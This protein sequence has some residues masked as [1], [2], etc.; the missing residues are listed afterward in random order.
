MKAISA[1]VALCLFLAEFGL[2]Q[3]NYATRSGEIS[4]FSSAPLEDI[5]AK[6][7]RVHALLDP[8]SG[9]VAVRMRMEDFSFE[10]ALMQKHFNE[11]F[12][13]SHIYPEA[14]FTGVISDF[15]SI[16]DRSGVFDVKVKGSFT[17]HGVTRQD[18]ISGTL[19]KT[20]TYYTFSSKFPVAV[21]D[22]NIIIPRLLFRNIAQV[23]EVR[24]YF[25]LVPDN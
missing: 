15:E 21:A 5:E 1:T 13:E 10:K 18:E 11:K 12:L 8:L 4:F 20:A 22:Y 24:T 7:N 23:V 17:I 16:P 14:H 3:N 2:A 6:N 9:R 25:R 19:T